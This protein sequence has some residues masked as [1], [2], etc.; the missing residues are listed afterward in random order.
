MEHFAAFVALDWS[1]TKHD[2]TLL[3]AS[4]NQKETY[5]IKHCAQAIDQWAITLRKKFAGQQIA[6]CLEQS[7]GP[8]HLCSLEI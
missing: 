1:D 6:V 2:V 3:D 7:R 5:T 8:A 4:T